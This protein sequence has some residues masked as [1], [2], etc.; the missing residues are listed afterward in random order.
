MNWKNSNF[1]I[2]YHVLGNCHTVVEGLRVLHELRQDR[3]FSIKLSIAESKRSESKVL[4]AK[5]ILSDK[6]ESNPAKLT[7]LC[8]IEEQSARSEI[9]Q[10]CYDAAI[11]ELSFIEY[12]IE[13]LEAEYGVKDINDFQ[14]VQPVEN[15]LDIIVR[16][17]TS[18][19][20]HGS[21]SPDLINESRNS[22]FRD[23]IVSAIYKCVE[24]REALTDKAGMLLFTSRT[25]FEIIVLSGIG[26][27]LD[28]PYKCK[29]LNLN[30]IAFPTTE[31]LECKRQP[32]LS[33]F[34]L[35]IS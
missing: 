14:R 15:A 23:N 19:I 29:L 8:N 17:Y 32:L 12:L 18:I 7:S 34:S 2:F 3:I 1:Q 30:H 16:A 24:M 4:A 10:P 22:P 6:N 33:Q 20:L 5:A 21:P 31:V 25:N 11:N 27:V 28:K 35:K 13:T 9:A 26:S